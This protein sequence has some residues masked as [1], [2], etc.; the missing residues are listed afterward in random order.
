MITIEYTAITAAPIFEKYAILKVREIENN[1]RE[2]T[3]RLGS[4]AKK[5]R[6]FVPR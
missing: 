1:M 6:K 2:I 4:F 3:R 5:S